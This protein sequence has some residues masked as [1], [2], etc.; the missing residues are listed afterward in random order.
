MTRSSLARLESIRLQLA[1]AADSGWDV[2]HMDVKSGF[3]NG[4]L[5]EDVYVQQPAGFT[6][7]G[8]EHLV[9]RLDKALYCLKKAP[10]AWNTK[11]DACLVKLDFTRCES[12][13]GMYARG[14][15]PATSSSSSWRCR[16]CSRCPTSG[17]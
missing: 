7:K 8:K 2:H 9:L 17:C 11:L 12:E 1:V 16:A 5:E 14:A 10:R 4:E 3:L 13:H 15:T 6:A